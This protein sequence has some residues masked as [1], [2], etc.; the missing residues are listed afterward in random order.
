MAAITSS[1]NQRVKWIRQLQARRSARHAGMHF[2][3]EGTRLLKEAL[4][5]GAEVPLVL[6]SDTPDRE[7]ERLATAFAERGSDVLSASADVLEMCSDTETPQGLI[8]VAVLPQLSAADIREPLLIV[9]RLRDPGNLGSLMRSA[10][11]AGMQLMLLTPGTV[12][13]LNPKVVRGAMGAHFHLPIKLVE[14]DELRSY[15]LGKNFWIAEAKRG[16]RYDRVDWTPPCALLL[17]GEA[18]GPSTDVLKFEHGY[19]HIPISSV[20]ESLNAA[21]AG[22]I[23]MFEIARQRGFE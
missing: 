17:G 10:L 23:L 18:H 15:L 8:A 12:D 9:D 13:P 22:S 20:S 3:I 21:V 14:I 4:D 6:H 1:T 7:A 5:S 16:S 2:V 19:V 11:A